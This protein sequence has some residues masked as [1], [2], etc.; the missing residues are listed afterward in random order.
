MRTWATPVSPEIECGKSEA[1]NATKD[2]LEEDCDSAHLLRRCGTA[3]FSH[4][5]QMRTLNLCSLHCTAC[6][7][8][9]K[10]C[11]KL[12]IVLTGNGS[13]SC[14]GGDSS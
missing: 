14:S 3:D 7:Q 13:S 5:R 9:H 11:M 1:P 6:T 8:A 2:V 10:Q 12:K 4:A